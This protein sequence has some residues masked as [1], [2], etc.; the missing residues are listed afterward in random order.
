M[1]DLETLGIGPNAKVISI[2]AVIFDIEKDLGEEFYQEISWESGDGELEPGTV[3]FWMREAA[4]GNLPP[5]DGTDSLLVASRN[6]I[7]WL[8]DIAGSKE[9]ILWANG[10]DFDIPKLDRIIGRYLICSRR[11]KYN[12]VRDYRTVAKLF[13]EYGIKPERSN[14]HNALADAKWQAE[15]LISILRN[16]KETVNVNI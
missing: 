10:T 13:S 8:D 9:L 5:M 6:F 1:V 11:W 2:G 16:L 7:G 4:K 15:H 12:N 3:K 14:H